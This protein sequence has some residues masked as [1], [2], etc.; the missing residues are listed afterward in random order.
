[1]VLITSTLVFGI[2]HLLPGDPVLIILGEQ[3]TADPVVVEKVRKRLKLDLP[4]TLQYAEWVKGVSYLDFGESLQTG[5]PVRQELMRRIPRSLE[6]IC[7]GL[8]LATFLGIP[9]ESWVARTLL[10]PIP[11]LVAIVLLCA[12]IRPNHAIVTFSVVL[13]LF[14]SGI[15]FS[16]NPFGLMYMIRPRSLAFGFMGVDSNDRVAYWKS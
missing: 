3:A 5:I 10:G 8:L 15:P 1:M 11:S 6:L 4:I 13:N 9:L 12:D 14:P 2:I 16:E 7:Y